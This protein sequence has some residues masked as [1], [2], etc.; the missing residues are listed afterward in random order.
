MNINLES[1]SLAERGGRA[2]TLVEL[3][4]VIG[5][6]GILASLLLPVVARGKKAVARTQCSNNLKQLALAINMY[7][8]DHGDQ[9]PGPIWQGLYPVYNSTTTLFMPYYIAKY[10]SLP[11]PSPAVLGVKVAVCPASAKIT[12]Q[13]LDGTL[14]TTLRQPISYIETIT[15]TNVQDDIVSRPFG[16]PYEHLPNNNGYTNEPPKHLKEIRNPSSSWALQDTDQQNA[17]SLA[18][19]YQFIPS[20]PAHD[21]VRNNL[22]FDWHVEAV[23]P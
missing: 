5:I 2:F 3:L 9:L 1:N 20:S 10:L 8:D 12:H 18:Q 19:Y 21:S 7:A 11:E 23:K 6:I 22:F 17:V 13:S 15:I 14:T 16:Y 4:V